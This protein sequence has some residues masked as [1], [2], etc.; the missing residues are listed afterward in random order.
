MLYAV[1]FDDGDTAE[2]VREEEIILLGG[3]ISIGLERSNAKPS[4]LRLGARVVSADGG[5]S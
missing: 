1:D 3:E 4:S 5:R 2:D